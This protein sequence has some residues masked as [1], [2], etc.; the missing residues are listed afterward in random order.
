[1]II[2]ERG[3]KSVPRAD[4]LSAPATPMPKGK[5]TRSVGA[6]KI[7]NSWWGQPTNYI[8]Q[9]NALQIVARDAKK[10]TIMAARSLRGSVALS[11]RLC[12]AAA[13]PV[14]GRE[15]LV[16]IE[17]NFAFARQIKRKRAVGWVGGWV[18]G[19]HCTRTA[20]RCIKVC[21][22]RAY[23]VCECVCVCVRCEKRAIATARAAWLLNCCSQFNRSASRGLCHIMLCRRWFACGGKWRKFPVG[24]HLP[25]NIS[26][27]GTSSLG[28]LA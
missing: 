14:A 20:L 11:L 13:A 4:G 5:K 9:R 18:A 8:Q 23:I 7:I 19:L 28:A 27:P 21:G 16:G 3:L 2:R 26:I 15:G 10:K 6:L 12:A 24:Q 25:K 22:R 17:Q 1:M